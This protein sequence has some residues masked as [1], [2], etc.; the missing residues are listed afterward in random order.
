MEYDYK[1]DKMPINEYWWEWLDEIGGIVPE[2]K[3][4]VKTTTR[5]WKTPM[6]VIDK[7][8]EDEIT[9]ISRSG[10][11]YMIVTY[12][13]NHS[14]EPTKPMVRSCDG[15]DSMGVIEEVKVFK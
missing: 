1:F 10:K 9:F 2:D 7:N 6:D 15:F 3:I 11:E 12:S 4:I 13:S 8:W 14:L 5:E